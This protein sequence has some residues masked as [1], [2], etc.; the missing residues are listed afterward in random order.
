M[1]LRGGRLDGTGRLKFSGN[2]ADP[3][4]PAEM[5]SASGGSWAFYQAVIG[6]TEDALY[7]YPS[8]KGCFAI[9]ADDPNFEDVIT[10]TAT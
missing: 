4:E 3:A 10:I 7:V 1:L 2:P 9:Q 8:T 5:L 6:G